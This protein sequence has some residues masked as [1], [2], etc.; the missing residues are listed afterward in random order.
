LT[1]LSSKFITDYELAEVIDYCDKIESLKKLRNVPP[2][3]NLWIRYG[4]LTLNMRATESQCLYYLAEIQNE[5]IAA[6]KDILNGYV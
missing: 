4:V 3:Y 6:K 1:N 5:M 2:V